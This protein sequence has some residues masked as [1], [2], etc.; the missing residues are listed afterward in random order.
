VRRLGLLAILFC[1]VLAPEAA[2]S[3]DYRGV[4]L[5]KATEV[6]TGVGVVQPLDCKGRPIR[7]AGLTANGSGFL[8][9]SRVVMT[10]EHGIS[11][12][13]RTTRGVCRLRVWLG[14]EWY[15]VTRTTVWSE[16]GKKTDRRGVDVGTFELARP[17]PGHIFRIADQPARV[18]DAV[19]TLGYP[20]GV[21]ISVAQ[22]IVRRTFKDYGIPTLAALI[23]T[24]AGNSGG[25]IINRDGDV[26]GILQRIFPVANPNRDGP[27]Q[28]G[29]IDLVRWWGKAA[30]ADLCRAYP[31][32]GIPDC[33]GDA[34]S[35]FTKVPVDL[36]PRR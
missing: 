31:D 20:F 19:A 8:I 10:V 5:E 35:S 18:G 24:E 3:A 28:N 27:N 33:P 14:G 26:V 25:P 16:R 9:G 11:N 15:P 6:A 13:L 29:G 7:Y 21:P 2:R 17:A 1:L 23:V 12:F 4:P 34:G 22:G 36:R 30:M 32:A